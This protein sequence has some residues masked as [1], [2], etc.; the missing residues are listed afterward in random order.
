MALRESRAS[1]RRFSLLMA[2]VS[3]G[4]AAHVAID[5]FADNLQ[6]SVRDQARAL[7]G[8]DLVLRSSSRFSPRAEQALAEI[9]AAEVARVTRFAAMA[10]VPRGAGTLLVQVSAVEGGYPFYGRIETDPPGGWPRLTSMDG[11]LV[12]PS[13]LV[14]L[15]ARV[16]DTLALG[17]ARFSIQGTLLD[18]PGD[19]GV[20][21]ALGPRIFIPGRRLGETGLLGFGA[22]AQYEAYLRLGPTTDPEGVADRYRLSLAAEHV[23]V[24]TVAEN[25]ERVS[26]SVARVGRYLG[27]VALIA[28]L[29]GGLGVGSAVHVFIKQRTESIAILR[30]LGAG[31]WGLLAIYLIQALLMGLLGALLGAVLGIALQALLPH[32]LGVFLPVGVSFRPSWPAIGSGARPAIEL[33]CSRSSPSARA[34]WLSPPSRPRA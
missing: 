34:S 5:S 33:L 22:R 31:A 8:A 24:R 13:V 1:F 7:L 16:G 2:S 6:E 10:Y 4:V 18:L 3:V 27:L 29:L 12:D 30:C 11:A 14:A 32:V 9:Q 17:E 28:L 23:T 21:A 25:Q 15:R 26:R 19:I 20:R